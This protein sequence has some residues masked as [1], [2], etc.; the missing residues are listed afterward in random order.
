MTNVNIGDSR[1][2]NGGSGDA[3]T[4][5]N[6]AELNI[7]RVEG[8]VKDLFIFGNDDSFPSNELG[9]VS[10]FVP[11]ANSVINFTVKNEF[12]AWNNNQGFSG[13]LN[14]PF[15]FALDGQPDSE[16]SINYDIFASFNR[17]ISSRSRFGSGVSEVTV[18]LRSSSESSC[19]DSKPIPEPTST[20]FF[21]ALGTIGVVQSSVKRNK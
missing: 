7:G 15:L 14:S 19:F 12:L 9:F 17:V 11:G 8:D 5:S 20:V 2:N 21:L 4:Q 3:A 18:C 1:T 6:D 16:G 13:S 10:N